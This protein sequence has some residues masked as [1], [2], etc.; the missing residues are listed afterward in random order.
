[1]G[2][3]I[4]FTTTARMPADAPLTQLRADMIMAEHHAEADRRKLP[5]RMPNVRAV[6]E[7]DE[8]VYCLEYKAPRR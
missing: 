6:T 1:M 2:R 5:R 8:M 3:P 4:L 7:G